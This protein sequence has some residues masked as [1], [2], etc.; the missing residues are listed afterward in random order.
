[1][2][3]MA[4][5]EDWN[6]A[7][8]CPSNK[9]ASFPAVLE[10][11]DGSIFVGM[12]APKTEPTTKIGNTDGAVGKPDD[13]D[14]AVDETGNTDGTVGKP[15][16]ADEAVDKTGN[17]DGAVD[18]PY[19]ADKAVDETGNTDRAVGEICNTDRAVD[20]HHDA[21][22]IVNKTDGNDR[23]YSRKNYEPA[24]IKPRVAFVRQQKHI[25]YLEITFTIRF[26]EKAGDTRVS[27]VRAGIRLTRHN[28][29]RLKVEQVTEK[30]A[31]QGLRRSDPDL[32]TIIK[33]KRLWVLQ[34]DIQP[35]PC[36]AYHLFTPYNYGTESDNVKALQRLF[37]EERRLNI[38]LHGIKVD[39]SASQLEAC[40]ADE[41]LENPLAK[42][43]PDHPTKMF[44]QAGAYIS[45]EDRP[46]F[47]PLP[48][49]PSYLSFEEYTT[50]LGFGLI[51]QHEHTV[52]CAGELPEHV[53]N[54][55]LMTIPGAGD[56]R[57]LGFLECPD[58]VKLRIRP[59]DQL[60]I[61]LDPDTDVSED[62]WFATAID[63]LPMASLRDVTILL[64][65]PW[66]REQQ[67]WTKDGETKINAI[68]T[69]LVASLHEARQKYIDAQPLEVKVRMVL[70]DKPFR[71]Q[72]NSLHIM[73]QE[74]NRQLQSI[75]LGNRFD[76][77][78]AV[79]LYATITDQQRDEVIDRAGLNRRQKDAVDLLGKM[80]GGFALIQGP[81]GTGKTYLMI[82]C[83]M[84]LLAYPIQDLNRRHRILIVAP[85]NDTVDHIAV[86]LKQ[87]AQERL[88]G[89]RKSEPIIVRCHARTT[90][91]EVA[92]LPAQQ[93]RP[94][95]TGSRPDIYVADE[96]TVD[97]DNMLIAR[98]V[99]SLYKRST[100]RP[101]P[102]S[103]PRLQHI[104]L[105]LGRWMNKF[106]G[107][108]D[109]VHADRDSWV[110]FLQMFDLYSSGEDMTSDDLKA[111]RAHTKAL[112][113]H[114]LS[115]AD[116]VVATLSA[117][118]EDYLRSY[119]H[120]DVIVIEEAAKVQEPEMWN[121]FACYEAGKYILIGDQKQLG[122]YNANS[123]APTF[124]Q[125]MRLSLF[126]RLM[127]CGF[128]YVILEEQH[129][130]NPEL[131][132]VVS[133][134]FYQ[135]ELVNARA[136]ER[137]HP[138][139]SKIMAAN[140]ALFKKRKSLLFIDTPQ[141]KASLSGAL[142][143]YH[144]TVTLTF[145]VNLVANLLLTGTLKPSDI[146]ILTP[147]HSQYLQYISSLQILQE[148]MPQ[149]D[150]G[151]VQVRKIDSYQGEERPVYFLDLTITDRTG[152]VREAG[153]LNVS[154]SRGQYGGYIIGNVEAIEATIRQE[155]QHV[156]KFLRNVI[157]HCKRAKRLVK[158]SA[159]T[160]LFAQSLGP[161]DIDGSGTAS[162]SGMRQIGYLTEHV[163]SNSNV[164][165][166]ASKVG[167][168]AAA[169]L[170]PTDQGTED[171]TDNSITQGNRQIDSSADQVMQTDNGATDTNITENWGSK[172]QVGSWGTTEEETSAW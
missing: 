106:A 147:Y 39:W 155:K 48:A 23:K 53:M 114:V 112:R 44:I 81:P 143:S 144:N 5:Q 161:V 73:Y 7:L 139:T 171:A 105:S 71:L 26:A 152:F 45:A 122:P 28:M 85:S 164:N 127:L 163:V 68:K 55:R 38:Y 63:P 70:S 24:G 62:A 140:V 74:S 97:L 166:A 133:D 54:L 66:D 141:A 116:V 129:R 159:D 2:E 43:Y 111:F 12:W 52:Q 72:I 135:G 118:G 15:D 146:V 83:I 145:T 169:V 67:E 11:A 93:Q 29:K 37:S 46:Q 165:I 78:P 32:S 51:N 4:T 92:W 35:M 21:H 58:T 95:E 65:R 87:L 132:S 121:V 47:A 160:V 59:G 64:T 79:D 167:D 9:K 34:L 130:M 13:A 1:M 156:L 82:N 6:E 102:I 125:P 107:V 172:P 138:T 18:K 60:Q 101:H 22:P 157:S 77:L 88:S 27:A 149:V 120:P 100:A 90:E 124:D 86:T 75:L 57:Y 153:R 42:W 99:D 89:F 110:E 14:E 98:M 69:E 113:E 76:N 126:A 119:F 115:N 150:I 151:A 117:A 94:R 142:R 30:T 168:E 36:Y 162:G 17:A 136:V 108:E 109:S 131:A 16:D 3:K 20:K 25:S 137:I 10:S 31:S 8:L 104:D 91:D 123:I 49:S 134:V 50:V 96:I 170:N 33:Q 158:Y 154:L 19:D 148:Q 128:L 61:N 84:P 40:F 103:D 80:P 41:V 56:R